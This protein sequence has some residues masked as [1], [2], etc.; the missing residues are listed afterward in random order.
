MWLSFA[1]DGVLLLLVALMFADVGLVDALG[2]RLLRVFDPDLDVGVALR[3]DLYP[4]L[5][6][7][8]AQRP[9]FGYGFGRLVENQLY[10]ENSYLYYGIK[11]GIL[12]LLALAVAWVLL[13][14][15]ALR[16]AR[17]HADPFSRTLAAGLAASIVSML[18][19][20]SINPLINSSVGMYFQA[21][22]GALLYGLRRTDA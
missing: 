14:A 1:L 3:L 10:Y 4:R 13:I 6:G 7:R 12:G 15:D 11:F 8:I 21:L 18:V 16:L 22:T 2:G 20:T 17:R 5:M 19:V 9:L